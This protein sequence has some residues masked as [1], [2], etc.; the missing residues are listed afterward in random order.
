MSREASAED[1]YQEVSE[2]Q[3][4]FHT[5]FLRWEVTHWTLGIAAIA[6]SAALS[7][8]SRTDSDT[9]LLFFAVLAPTLSGSLALVRPGAL[10]TKY[11][12]AATMLDKAMRAFRQ[13]PDDGRSLR[14][15][16]DLA[17]DMVA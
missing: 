9:S 15:A 1:L 4:K 17:T 7:K 10:S 13:Q 16:L 6:A 2:T 14:R 12:K 5:L 8:L 11:S 3:S